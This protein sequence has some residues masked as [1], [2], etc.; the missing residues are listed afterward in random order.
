MKIALVGTG[1]MGRAVEA[2]AFERGHGVV[3]RFN[4]QYPLAAAEDVSA[5]HGADVVIDF[6]LPALAL[7]HINRYCQ[8]N[9]AA[10]VGTTGWYEGLDQVRTWVAESE[11]A[12]LYAPNFSLGVALLTR[13]LR[14]L[15][16]LLERLPEYDVAVHEAHHTGKVDSP[17]GT[18][19]LL[20]RVLLDG[21]SRKTRLE[22][23]TQHQPIDPRALHVTSSRLGS[24][25]GEHTVY[26]DSPFDA[27]TLS[28]QAK[29]RRGFAFGALKAAEWLPGRH[30]L[31]TLDD[32]LRSV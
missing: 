5:L 11:T 32:L 29:N 20:A 22:T 18:A 16:P 27:I 26:L 4:T 14:G 24:V 7:G 31:F 15:V 3:A 2:L 9:Q 17:S 23:E 1:R 19:L 30:G 8:W 21:L 12:L 10:V 13:A 28:H 25:F 6:S